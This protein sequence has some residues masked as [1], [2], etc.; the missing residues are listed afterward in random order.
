M[1]WK[2]HHGDGRT[3]ILFRG[4]GGSIRPLRKD[5]L[6]ISKVAKEATESNSPYITCQEVLG[7]K[8]WRVKS[9]VGRAT[10]DQY[11]RELNSEDSSSLEI[12]EAIER[13]FDGL[14]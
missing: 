4:K 11:V 13:T 1:T 14:K 10:I 6:V 5:E 8:A 7:R 2:I 3:S 9:E 12:L